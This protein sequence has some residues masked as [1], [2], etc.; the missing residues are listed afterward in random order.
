MENQY[1]IYIE[2][3]EYTEY[4]FVNAVSL[5]DSDNPGVDPIKDKLF[6]GDVFSIDECKNM[7]LLHS[8]V[9]SVESMP[10]VLVLDQNKTFGKLNGKNLYKCIPDDRRLPVFLVPY[11]IKRMG[12]KKKMVNKYVTFEYSNWNSKHPYGKIKQNIGNVDQL[13]NFYEYQLYCKSLNASIQG[14]NRA[15]SNALKSKSHLEFIDLIRVKYPNLEDRTG[16][17][18]FTI[19]GEGCEDYDDAI[20]FKKIDNRTIISI[21]I[22][23]VTLWMEL[24]GLW[25]SFSRRISTIYLPDRKRPMLPTVLSDCLCSLQEKQVR[26][27]FAIDIEIIENIITNI[28]FK[29][30]SIKVVKNYRY[31]EDSLLYMKDYNLLKNMVWELNRRNK[32]TSDITNSYDVITYL[33]I[34]MNYECGKEMIK[35]NN[36][37]FRSAAFGKETIIPNDI[38]EDVT[39]F[40]KIWN[41]SCGQYSTDY[42]KKHELLDLESYI[43]ITSPIRR[44]VDLLNMIQFQINNKMLELSSD[45]VEFY[46][47][48][49]SELDYVNVTMRAIRKIQIDCNMLHMCFTNPEVIEKTY[50][51][52]VFDKI[53]RNDGLYQYIVYLPELKMASRITVRSEVENFKRREFQIYL[54]M[55]QNKLKQKIRLQMLE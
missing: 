28:S 48:W 42:S 37:V 51:G 46:N 44:L 22:S 16:E 33:M 27:A 14:F 25:K 18:I 19:D 4:S 39:K 7:K 38:P 8:T 36:G 49:I 47:Q 6:S 31:E 34:L 54:F 10:G 20:G 1:R 3:R 52:Y 12:F 53:Q 24:L 17:N 2:N 29:N 43:H 40:L 50:N 23:N 30:C 35:N 9:H 21:Y 5:D 13:D 32:Y 45:A 26:F 55:D 11:E 15:T 41:S